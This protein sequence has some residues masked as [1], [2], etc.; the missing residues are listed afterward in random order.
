MGNRTGPSR[1]VK[2]DY[3]DDTTDSERRARRT[4]LPLAGR[5]ERAHDA[6]HVTASMGGYDV[7]VVR[8]HCTDTLPDVVRRPQPATPR[9]SYIPLS[10]ASGRQQYLVFRFCVHAYP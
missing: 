10:Q 1:C 7:V 3:E 4:R 5:A 9:L 8:A 6:S 2:L